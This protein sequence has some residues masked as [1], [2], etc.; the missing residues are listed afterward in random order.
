[1][2][3]VYCFC[4]FMDLSH[5]FT[6]NARVLVANHVIDFDEQPQIESLVYM[7]QYQSKFTVDDH[8]WTKITGMVLCMR[9]QEKL[10]SFVRACRNL[11]VLW[12]SKYVQTESGKTL[13]VHNFNGTTF[14][15]C[16]D[17]DTWGFYPDSVLQSL[18]D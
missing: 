10:Q 11:R 13:K 6:P 15:E 16:H 12:K 1:M 14:D 3:V 2:G 4:G 7:D 17:D 8:D 5:R 18:F 9:D